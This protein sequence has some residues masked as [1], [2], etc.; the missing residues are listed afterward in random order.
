ME[1]GYVHDGQW[2]VLHKVCQGSQPKATSKVWLLLQYHSHSYP[3]SCNGPPRYLLCLHAL[4]AHTLTR[5][6]T[7][8]FEARRAQ[9]KDPRAPTHFVFHGSR[10]ATEIIVRTQYVV[11]CA[12]P[13]PL[14]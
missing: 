3:T 12:V 1:E 6:H 14:M 9:L 11:V 5:S 13:L 8:R 2:A 10:S 7:H 4:H